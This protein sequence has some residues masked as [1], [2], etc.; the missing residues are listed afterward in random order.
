MFEGENCRHKLRTLNELKELE[1]AML[2]PPEKA[3]MPAAKPRKPPVKKAPEKKAAKKP[4]VKKAKKVTKKPAVK[5]SV[6]K[7][8]K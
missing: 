4:P 2:E 5:K 7:K 3:V 6:K 8:G 1:T